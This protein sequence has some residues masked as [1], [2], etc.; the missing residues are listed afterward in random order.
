MV[1]LKSLNPGKVWG[2]EAVFLKVL[3]LP[4]KRLCRE[5]TNPSAWEL[6][7]VRGTNMAGLSGSSVCGE[8]WE[9]IEKER[10]ERTYSVPLSGPPS[11][12]A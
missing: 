2:G 10:G 9:K 1:T 3:H 5:L 12:P 6:K 8:D 4:P 7:H 11:C